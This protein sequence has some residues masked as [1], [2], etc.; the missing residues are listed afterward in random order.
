[1][2][3][4]TVTSIGTC[5]IDANQAGN[6]NYQSAPQVTQSATAG[7]IYWSGQGTIGRS[8]LDAGSANGNW[9]MNGDA[10]GGVAV[11]GSY[12]YWADQGTIA[13]ANLDGTGANTSF[14]TGLDQ[15]SDVAVDGSY[16][17][18]SSASGTI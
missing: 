9:I 18:W 17:Y 3:T 4:V 10:P 1:G 13:R 14:I 2:S 15:P 16:I 12:I 5:T 6:A 11:D 8:N 7:H